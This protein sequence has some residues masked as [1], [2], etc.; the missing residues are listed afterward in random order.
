MT[1]GGRS[2]RGV[3]PVSPVVGN[4]PLAATALS[5]G[6]RLS[7]TPRLAPSLWSAGPRLR[8]EVAAGLTANCDL[9]TAPP[10]P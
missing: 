7:V 10:A 4:V 5:F 9:A 8:E 1:L 2:V 6:G 3:V